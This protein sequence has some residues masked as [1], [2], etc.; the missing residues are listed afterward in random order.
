M[1]DV[2]GTG[3]R[4]WTLAFRISAGVR[5]SAWNTY[6]NHQFSDAETGCRQMSAACHSHYRNN[7]VLDHW[8]QDQQVAYVLYKDGRRVAHVLFD[9]R[10]SDKSSW[11]NQSRSLESAFED[12]ENFGKNIALFGIGGQMEITRHFK[13]LPY[14]Y[15][16]ERVLGWTAVIDSPSTYCNWET[17]TGGDYPRILYARNG[18][19]TNMNADDVVA[20][21]AIGVFVR[22]WRK[23][24]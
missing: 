23:Y 1:F 6:M 11:F 4:E 17:K 20:A 9:A 15:G 14:N 2:F 16:C 21:D 7:D 18:R 5:Q 22:R 13:I 10:G 24:L 8:A 3:K 12:L 19:L